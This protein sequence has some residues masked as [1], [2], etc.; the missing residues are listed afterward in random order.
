MYSKFYLDIIYLNDV[1]VAQAKG[2]LHRAGGSFACSE[3]ER[4]WSEEVVA[5]CEVLF[6]PLPGG[7]DENCAKPKSG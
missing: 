4:A 2:P 1:S 6:G 3:L 7:S 5:C